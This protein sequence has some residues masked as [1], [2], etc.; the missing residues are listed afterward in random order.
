MFHVSGRLS[1]LALDTQAILKNTSI[2][3]S[4][5]RD[6]SFTLVLFWTDPVDQYRYLLAHEGL[7][8]PEPM[9][10]PRRSAEHSRLKS[11]LQTS[12][13]RG[14]RRRERIP[15]GNGFTEYYLLGVRSASTDARPAV[16][17]VSRRVSS[18]T[19]QWLAQ[20]ERVIK[21][22]DDA[23]IRNNEVPQRSDVP[24]YASLWNS[25]RLVLDKLRARVRGL[26][27]FLRI[28]EVSHSIRSSVGDSFSELLRSNSQ[29]RVGV[30]LFT[31]DSW[32]IPGGIG[33]R[34]YIPERVHATD[35]EDSRVFDYLMKENVSENEHAFDWVHR[36]S[37]PVFLRHPLS[38]T[39]RERLDQCGVDM[40]PSGAICIAPIQYDREDALVIGLLLIS[41]EN[42]ERLSPA[43][44]FLAAR[45]SQE[46]VGY[47]ARS[48]AA[49]G[50]PWWP[51]AKVSRGTN[52]ILLHSDAKGTRAMGRKFERNI[53]KVAQS[54]MP[55]G[56]RVE[57]TQLASGLTDSVV[58]RAN[59]VDVGGI[60]EIP[61]VLKVGDAQVL[62]DELHRYF[63]YVHNKPVGGQSR[64]DV[65]MCFPEIQW[66]SRKHNTEAAVPLTTMSPSDSIAPF[67]DRRDAFDDA[68]STAAIAYT[69][70]GTDAKAV[71]WRE[72][73][74]AA[75]LTDIER[76]I[77]KAMEHLS[78]WHLR[79][80]QEM[81]QLGEMLATPSAMRKKEQRT[82]QRDSLKKTIKLMEAIQHAA[83]TKG[84]AFPSCIVHGDLHCDNLFALLG[85][86]GDLE[87]K[88]LDVAIIDWGKV[89]SGRYPSTDLGILLADLVFRVRLGDEGTTPAWALDYLRN[90][91]RSSGLAETDTLIVYCFHLLRMLAWGPLEGKEPWT[92][93][94]GMTAALETIDH[95]LIDCG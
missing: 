35:R 78:C 54:M 74:K 90:Y 20:R 1:Q 91:A 48:S 66:T 43:F 75:S 67:S 65:A 79:G 52:A 40:P 49:P 31:G 24:M 25:E 57:L 33:E 7:A 73:A 81:R 80:R 60:V 64:V 61:R 69:F 21:E 77:R 30:Y 39:W 37:K 87:N 86:D 85:R 32:Q 68:T 59:V 2:N 23:I 95:I 89:E 17:W 47:L 93:E 12:D 4:P 55:L 11:K 41:I 70:V 28:G 63:R 8:E 51:E 42:V 45:V 34:S 22:L 15:D 27:P 14:F 83:G 9:F 56:S 62:G 84:G 44:S 26:G 18:D 92:S 76:G 53:A 5:E 19:E 71:A 58:Y 72:W 36:S 6:D 13:H 82:S 29:V 50:F 94:R 10:T 38:R 3:T 88:L 46:I 16:L